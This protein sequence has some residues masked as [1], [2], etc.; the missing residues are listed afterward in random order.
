MHP[1]LWKVRSC[2]L[3]LAPMAFRFVAHVGREPGVKSHQSG[4]PVRSATGT[5]VPGNEQLHGCLVIL[6]L[7]LN[8]PGPCLEKPA[9][10]ECS[11]T[12]QPRALAATA[13]AAAAGARAFRRSSRRSPGSTASSGFWPASTATLLATRLSGTERAA[14]ALA[15]VANV[16]PAASHGALSVFVAH[17]WSPFL[18]ESNA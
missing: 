18:H 5:A 4:K 13:A 16:A 15:A 2:N 12:V 17:K 11:A 14:A 3:K 6:T 9:A 7:T 10:L 8:R 1:R